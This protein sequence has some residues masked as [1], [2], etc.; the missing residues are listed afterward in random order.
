VTLISPHATASGPRWSP[1]AC[2]WSTGAAAPVHGDRQTE[3]RQGL[4]L[5]L[6]SLA[7]TLTG[8]GSHAEAAIALERADALLTTEE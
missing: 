1:K 4:G 7:D 6:D 8:L 5:A 3:D 2:S